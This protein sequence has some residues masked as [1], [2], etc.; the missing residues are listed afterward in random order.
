MDSGE[1]FV[2]MVGISTM[3]MLYVVLWVY[4]MQQA[5]HAVHPLVKEVIQ[6]GWMMLFVREMKTRLL[7]VHIMAGAHITVGMER[8]LVSFVVI[9]NV[10]MNC[11]INMFI[12]LLGFPGKLINIHKTF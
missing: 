7:N 5:H 11:N 9:H 10:T 1:Q 4:Q 12:K 8:M 6:Y 2:M 3:L